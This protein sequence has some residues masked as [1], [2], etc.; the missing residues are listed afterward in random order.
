MSG[1]GDP[2]TCAKCG[3]EFLKGRS[4]EE[5]WDEVLDVEKPENIAQGTGLT[6]DAC[7]QELI[8]WAWENHPGLLRDL[9]MES[10]G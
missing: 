6:C 8:A 10:D 3:G 5:S 1:L 9:G 4:D 2:F 7:Y